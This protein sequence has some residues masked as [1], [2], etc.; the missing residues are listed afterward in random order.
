MTERLKYLVI[1]FIVLIQSNAIAQNAGLFYTD[2]NQNSNRLQGKLQGEIY[3]LN[4]ISNANY[5]LQSDWLEGAITLY[6]GD[7]FE[8]LKMRYLAYGDELVV[9]NENNRALFIVDKSTVKQFTVI[10]SELSQS[11]K[12]RKFINLDSL[13]IAQNKTFFEELYSGSLQLLAFHRIEMKK[14]RPYTDVSGRLADTEYLLDTK[15]YVLAGDKSLERIQL[16]AN[17]I[18]KL[19][20]EN[21]KEIRQQ[22]R[23]SRINIKDEKTAIQA[24]RVLDDSG[25]L[26]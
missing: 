13:K 20:P 18:A 23:K 11:S 17:Y 8:G 6:D 15:Y 3:Y 5:F 1:L 16:K 2:L 22:L 10:D 12:Q 14:V 19:F 4:V 25:L 9:Y 7:I 26:K 24:F 21:K